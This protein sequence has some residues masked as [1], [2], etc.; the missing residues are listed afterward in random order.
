MKLRV[1]VYLFAL[2]VILLLALTG[3]NAQ[4]TEKP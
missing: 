4:F 1:T 2:S 3:K